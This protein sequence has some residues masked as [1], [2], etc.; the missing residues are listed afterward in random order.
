MLQTISR[1]PQLVEEDIPKGL[2]ILQNFPSIIC[3]RLLD[4]R[5]GESILDLCAAPGNKTTHISSLMNNT[6]TLI[7]LEK[8]KSKIERLRTYCDNF[9]CKNVRIFCF[10]STKSV[11]E[12]EDNREIKDG[13]PFSRG[14][15]D[16]VLL[17]GPCSVLGKRPQILNKINDKE[18]RSFVPLQRK[19]FSAVSIINLLVHYFIEIFMAMEVGNTFAISSIEQ[20]GKFYDSKRFFEENSDQRR[21]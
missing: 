18:F 16:R 12:V 10:D 1:V 14:S 13:P 15:F 20:P 8:I 21:N 19:L 7:A 5:P 3:S 4:P 2:G 6:G 9:N 11:D 17:D